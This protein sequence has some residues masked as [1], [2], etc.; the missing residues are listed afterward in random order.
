MLSHGKRWPDQRFLRT[1]TMTADVSIST[2]AATSGTV[3][4][5]LAVWTV[6]VVSVHNRIYL[7]GA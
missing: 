2:L 5:P 7:E 6:V 1:T 4:T 3:T